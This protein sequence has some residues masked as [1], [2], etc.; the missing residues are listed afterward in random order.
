MSAITSGSWP[1]FSAQSAG[2]DPCHGRIPEP[3]SLPV[4]LHKP[5][6]VDSDNLLRRART[7]AASKQSVRSAMPNHYLV[8]VPVGGR[9][10][11]MR[12]CLGH[13]FRPQEPR[14]VVIAALE[15]D[16]L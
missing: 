6:T 8:H 3:R 16:Q 11:R 7:T 10:D 14:R 15:F 2:L 1:E 13:S 9:G 4:R 12:D 5:R